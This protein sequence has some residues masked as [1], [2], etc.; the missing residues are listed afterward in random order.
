MPGVEADDHGIYNGHQKTADPKEGKVFFRYKNP[1]WIL[2][3][4]EKV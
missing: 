4:P 1:E 3:A 2:V